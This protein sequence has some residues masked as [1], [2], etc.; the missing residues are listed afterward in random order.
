MLI[1]I[2]ELER[3]PIDFREELPP[4][5]IDFFIDEGFRPDPIAPVFLIPAAYKT[6]SHRNRKYCVN[7]NG[8]L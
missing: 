1:E 3:H 7:A 8:L 2:E 6:I 4:G 5:A